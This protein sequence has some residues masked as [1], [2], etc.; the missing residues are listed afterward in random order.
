MLY[1]SMRRKRY[2]RN[3]D[4]EDILID[5]THQERF[6]VSSLEGQIVASISRIPVMIL[7]VLVFFVAFFFMGRLYFLQVVNGAE[8]RERS[9]N[10]R[11][12][13]KILF[14]K[15]GT[16]TDRN[17]DLLAWN[18]PQES[19][20]FALRGYS[21]HPGFAHIL[22]YVTH[23]Q[24]DDN[25]NFYQTEYEPQSGVEQYFDDVLRGE[26]GKQLVEVDARGE[27]KAGGVLIPA[28]DGDTLTLSIDA[29]LQQ[30]MYERIEDLATDKGFRGGVGLVMDVETGELIVA[31]NYP[32]YNMSLF[33]GGDR[34]YINAL[35][36][37]EK[38]PY[39]N[40]YA[41]GLFT[42]GSI[43]KP[44]M[45]LA[46]LQEGIITPITEF[47]S[48]GKLVV[49]N[50]Y[51]PDK[52]SVFTDWKAHGWVNVYQAIAHSSNIF[53]YHVGGGFGSVPGLG[54][55]KIYEYM[56]L[57]G[58]GRPIEA[59]YFNAQS[60]TVPNPEWKKEVFDE[61]W[62][63]GDT[64]FTSI[65]QYGFQTTPLQALR[66]VSG[67]ATGDAVE[68]HLILGEEGNK[69]SYDFIDPQHMQAVRRGMKEATQY[70]TARSLNFAGVTAGAKTGTAELGVS[71]DFVNSW[72]MGFY[73]YD[74]P[75]YAFVAMM[76]H[77]PR[78]NLV[79]ASYIMRQFLQYGLDT[80][81]IEWME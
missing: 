59:E 71:K 58:F 11:L 17:G 16:I 1:K 48:T 62:R 43:V 9:E 60:G 10:N 68:P 26:N 64:Y 54:I 80:G 23:P 30:Y 70:G 56:N 55:N 51:F 42:P 18:I 74:E 65:G 76:E 37:D 33:A 22:G 50:P 81:K 47:E 46:G 49:P 14:A 73:P 40:R 32:G 52:P 29:D 75:K 69:T 8:F 78:T 4:P 72:T 36:Q 41:Q 15:R 57:F 7:V 5:V 39:L 19:D 6:D 12:D 77:G 34:D 79:G 38:N 27:A 13:H 3:L 44:F 25:G 2:Q 31:T 35:N 45:A 63:L 24:K 66:A 21:E 53:F 67:I 28:R 61:E 20:T